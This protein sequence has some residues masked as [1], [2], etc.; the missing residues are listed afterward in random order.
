MERRLR[1]GRRGFL[2]LAGLAA[3]GTTLAACG[4]SGGSTGGGSSLSAGG[5]QTV[6]IQ[7]QDFRY[8]TPLTY[9]GRYREAPLLAQQ[10][11]A[12]KLPK[13][14]E[15][16]PEVP[17]VVPNP[18]AVEGRY[19]GT[20]RWLCS[21]TTDW[22]T[23]HLVQE[24]TYGHSPLRFLHD[25][26]EIGPGL[27]ESWSASADLTTWTFRFRR[28]LRWSD[29]HPWSVD[30]VLYWWEDEVMEPALG[31]V[32]PQEWRSGRGTPATPR[33]V[34]DTT[35]E[36]SYDSPTPLC[37]DYAAAWVKRGLGP[38]WMDAKH[39]MSQFHIRYNRSLDA[40]TWT[41]VYNQKMDWA[42]NPDNPTM[43]GWRLKEYKQGEFAIFERNPYY[44][45]IDRWGN[46]LPFIDTL[47]NTNNQDPQA[48]R[49]AM[50]QGKADLIDGFHVGITL[51]DVS[52]LVSTRSQNKLK[53]TYWDSGSGTASLWFFN[54]DHQDESLRT[55]FRD[56]TFRQAM[57]L[58]YDRSRARKVIY[59]NEGEATTGTMSPKSIEFNTGQGATVYR[60][61]RDSFVDHDP[62]RAR[63]MLDAIGVRMGS[64]GWRTLPD[65]SPLEITLD[66]P[67][68]TTNEHIT[69]N[70]LLAQD[71]QAIGIN[72]RANPVTPTAFAS[73][74]AAGQLQTTTAW[75]VSDGPND[76]FYAP[77]LV[78]QENS[79]WAPLEGTWYS[80]QGTS[81][82]NVDASVDPWHR[83]PPNL[84]PDQGGVVQRLQAIYRQATVEPD[85]LKRIHYVWQLMRVHIQEGPFFSGTVAN[86]P[87]VIA[88]H[89]DM[90]NV[91]LRDQLPLH[92]F[93]NTWALPQPATYEP[94]S[95]FWRNPDQHS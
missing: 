21:D 72:A 95:Y 73:Q 68:N 13:V 14:E 77:W 94:E 28:G 56:K 9:R 11:A 88:F 89:Q 12:G 61:W 81:R 7:R 55:L 31:Q 87:Q 82:A 60:Q 42:T 16:L 3:A 52:T 24:S 18:W 19:G 91:P 57:S 90:G 10:V 58:A 71:W 22:G 79:R 5:I 40:D 30:D 86:Y 27:A 51:S 70:Q 59:F 67:A 74:W 34:D 2:R 54:Y 32:P 29:G 23:C 92:G 41:T 76:L 49:I 46:Q 6:P 8:A 37:A 66:Y 62:A 25:G 53:I 78:P 44:W 64:G 48:M 15:R 84:A 39:Y 4:G 83:S 26:Q 47:V 43:T 63:Q 80:L 75:E 69:K 50:Q 85:F 20:M 36:M 35:L 38:G 1:I 17:Y 93:T 45:V 33:K 65:G